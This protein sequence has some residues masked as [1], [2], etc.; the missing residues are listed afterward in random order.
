MGCVCDI[1]KQ[2]E[3][4]VAQLMLD[5]DT[6]T[7]AGYQSADRASFAPVW[8]SLGSIAQLLCPDCHT[9]EFVTYSDSVCECT[10]CGRKLTILWTDE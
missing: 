5:G 10:S 6:L 9:D 7:I 8:L 2:A 4:A 1:R 3:I